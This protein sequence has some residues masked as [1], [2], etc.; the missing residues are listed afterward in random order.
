MD[1]SRVHN[2]RDGVWLIP[3]ETLFP[4]L[5]SGLFCSISILFMK[6][7]IFFHSFM[8]QGDAEALLLNADVIAQVSDSP[9]PEVRV[10]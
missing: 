3:A 7:L 9:H 10:L 8:Y 1:G 4:Y 5:S 6:V 2:N